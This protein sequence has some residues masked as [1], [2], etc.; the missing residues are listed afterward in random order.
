MTVADVFVDRGKARADGRDQRG[1]VRVVQR[2]SEHSPQRFGSVVQDWDT[3][4]HES[5]RRRSQAEQE[6]L[7]K[8]FSPIEEE[9]DDMEDVSMENSSLEHRH[10]DLPLS[11]VETHETHKSVP[12]LHQEEPSDAAIPGTPPF[13][14]PGSEELGGD[15][16]SPQQRRHESRPD[17]PSRKRKPSPEQDAPVKEPRLEESTTA[18]QP[19]TKSPEPTAETRALSTPSPARRRSIP[20]FASPKYRRP[21]VSE[22]SHSPSKQGLGLGIAKSPSNGPF[23][24]SALSPPLN[25]GPVMENSQSL[26]S[27]M[28]KN[29]PIS[30]VQQRRSVS[31]AEANDIS[32]GV[33]SE[34]TP[35]NASQP[36]KASRDTSKSSETNSEGQKGQTVYPA[37]AEKLQKLRE[38]AERK[39]AQP[40]EPAGH[41]IGKQDEKAKKDSAGQKVKTRNQEED[42]SRKEEKT[43]KEE[44]DTANKQ[45]GRERKEEEKTKNQEEE[46]TRR[47]E[48]NAGKP[49]EANLGKKTKDRLIRDQKDAEEAQAIRDKLHDLDTDSRALELLERMLEIYTKIEKVKTHGTATELRNLRKKLPRLQKKLEQLENP[50]S[51]T[52]EPASR[53]TSRANRSIPTTAPAASQGIDTSP[54]WSF[55]KPNSH[56]RP[57]VTSNQSPRSKNDQSASSG[58][59]SDHSINGVVDG[60][61]AQDHVQAETQ[62]NGSKEESGKETAEEPAEE[63]ARMF[64][65]EEA[66][67]SQGRET[68]E[69]ESESSESES[70]SDDLLPSHTPPIWCRRSPVR[71][72]SSTAARPTPSKAASLST[73]Q[74][75]SS[76]LTAARPT[77][78]GLLQYQQE[79]QTA[80]QSQSQAQSTATNPPERQK[81][82]EPSASNDS[83]SDESSSDSD[84]DD[85]SAQ[86]DILPDGNAGKLRK[87]YVT[88]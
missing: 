28:R 53:L 35:Q 83:E 4:V 85:D 81:M 42:G 43:R 30:Q 60:Q 26:Q 87:P 1:T 7:A 49:Q 33:G 6:A 31:F 62:L 17:V 70:E 64:I 78:K 69:S 44:E 20:A 57:S 41:K 36:P 27:A 61:E 58:E 54:S 68:E 9:D 37:S 22:T 38:K 34:S 13:N 82:Y 3:A 46:K 59:Q 8:R 67:G 55:G 48:E 56:R 71:N 50:S 2:P 11:S 12:P 16:F 74:P 75:P 25:R 84:D 86:G 73:P 10:R 5:K 32:M 77:L 52:P 47:E 76:Q 18:G 88:K 45:A 40:N 23:P 29:T 79:E 80:R 66:E 24:S 21:R 39:F 14:R 72:Q 19:T 65:D 15:I 51:P 63:S